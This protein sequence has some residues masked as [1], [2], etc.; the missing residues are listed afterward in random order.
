MA[1]AI[2]LLLFLDR[3]FG[4]LASNRSGEWLRILIEEGSSTYIAALLVPVMVFATRKLP[5]LGANWLRNL[6]L[7]GL[8]ALSV[9]S[10][11]T[12]I[13]YA[14]RHLL[15]A[16]P[17]VEGAG[18]YSLSLNRYLLALPTEFIVYAVIVALTLVVDRYRGVRNRELEAVELRAQLTQAQLLALQRQLEPQFMFGT[19]RS[20][21]QLVYANPKAAEEMIARMTALLR[22]SFSNEQSHETTLEHELRVL[23]LYLEIMRLRYAERLFVQVDSPVQLSR[24]TMPRFLLQPLVE[25]A[26]RDGDDPSMTLVAARISVRAEDGVLVIRVRDQSRHEHPSSQSMAITNAADRIAKL[27]GPGYGLTSEVLEEGTQITVRLP[28]RLP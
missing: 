19:L 26:L 18:D 24:A 20:I 25:N 13:T 21:A 9:G 6:P 12:T 5:P 11:H 23:D 2:S 7:H 10:I 16:V 28:L 15:I 27:Y 3:Y 4:R 22:H 17:G 1:T 8:I 14:L